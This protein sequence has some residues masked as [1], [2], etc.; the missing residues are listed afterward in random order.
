MELIEIVLK[1]LT[2]KRSNEELCKFW[3]TLNIAIVEL[4]VDDPILARQGKLPKRF[5]ESSSPHYHQTPKEMYRM[6]YFETY[7]HVINGTK[8]CFHQPDFEVYKHM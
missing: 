1:S 8:E 5:D 6:I 7:D 2:K 4:D 3:E